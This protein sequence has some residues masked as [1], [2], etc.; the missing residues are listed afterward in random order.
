MDDPTLT[1]FLTSPE[2]RLA[3]VQNFLLPFIRRFSAND[4]RLML[5]NPSQKIKDAT[6][7]MVQQMANGGLR[8]VEQDMLGNDP[9][10]PAQ[11]S[12]AETTVRAAHKAL[13]SRLASKSVITHIAGVP[14]AWNPSKNKNKKTKWETFIQATSQ[15]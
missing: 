13:A 4:C 14:G 1:S 7:N 2:A 8:Q 12:E 3:Y 15:W 5:T 10:H 6:L 9:L 11:R